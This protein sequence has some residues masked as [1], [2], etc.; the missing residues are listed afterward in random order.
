MCVHLT[1]TVG[2]RVLVRSGWYAHSAVTGAPPELSPLLVWGCW[3][4]G[5]TWFG[6]ALPWP[7]DVSILPVHDAVALISLRPAE[8]L[9]STDSGPYDPRVFAAGATCGP[10]VL[11]GLQP[12]RMGDLGLPCG[13]CL[14]PGNK[15]SAWQCLGEGG[16]EHGGPS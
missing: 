7:L 11:L 16:G 14:V 5:D 12:M 3:I 13:S 4:S 9:V 15:E 6:H 10:V 2:K 8:H 1:M